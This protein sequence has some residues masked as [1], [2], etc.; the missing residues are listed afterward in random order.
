MFILIY[1]IRVVEQNRER[2][3]EI[4]DAIVFEDRMV[5]NLL[6]QM[7]IVKSEVDRFALYE[8]LENFFYIYVSKDLSQID[9]GDLFNDILKITHKH[10]LI[11]P[12][13]FI[14]LAKSM[15]VI[16]GIVSDFDTK[17][18][19]MDIAKTYLKESK[20]FSPLKH[21]TDENLGLKA[22]QLSADTLELP[23]SLKKGLDTLV[24]GRT[25]LNLEIL[26]WD[27]KSVEMNK[28]VNRLVF[29]I[30]IA[31]LILASAFIIVSASSPSLSNLAILI[32]LGAGLM[33][34]WLLISII[35]SGTL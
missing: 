10:S 16:E 1:C 21:L 8:D 23:T 11:M 35:R 18:N 34:L 27:K 5:E 13:D 12:N 17:V 30:I 4:L 28:M 19:V 24:K 2:L 15:G 20:G 26:N 32:F 22:I 14:M 29:A 9:I 25:R 33:G 6:L 3:I 31:A 7:A